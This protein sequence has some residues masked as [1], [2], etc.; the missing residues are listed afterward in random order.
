M[1]RKTEWTVENKGLK[2]F[3]GKVFCY[4]TRNCLLLLPDQK[5]FTTATRP[6]TV[7]NFYQTR[8]FYCYYQT[9]NFYCYSRPETF[10]TTTRPE[11]F[12]T[13][14][15]PETCC[16]YYL[17]RNCLLLIPDQKL[18][19]AILPDQKLCTTFTRQKLLLLLDHK[20]FATTTRP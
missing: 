11:T 19:A 1:Y 9:R 8:N 18:F 13:T 14:T 20:L 16:Y 3:K 12:T 17:T 15:R 4:Q 5:L 7:N 6:E 10:T 2:V